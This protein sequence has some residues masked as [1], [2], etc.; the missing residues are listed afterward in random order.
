MH[1]GTVRGQP[2]GTDPE[3]RRLAAVGQHCGAVVLKNET[4]DPAYAR[5]SALAWA[6]ARP[7]LKGLY[8][9]RLGR[10]EAPVLDQCSLR[11]ATHLL[12][13]L[14]DRGREASDAER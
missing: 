1:P 6:C 2:H 14:P 8:A 4:S 12:G 7:D 9:L 13:S 5:I 3:V 10:A 11:S